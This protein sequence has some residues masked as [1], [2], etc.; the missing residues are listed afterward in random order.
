MAEIASNNIIRRWGS[1][2]IGTLFLRTD[3]IFKMSAIVLTLHSL[4]GPKKWPTN[5]RAL[6]AVSFISSLVA[7]YLK[8]LRKR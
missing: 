6:V 8:A 2:V 3:G 5:C 4:A 7:I 1:D